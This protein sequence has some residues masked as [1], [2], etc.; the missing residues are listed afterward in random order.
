MRLAQRMTEEGHHIYQLNTGN[1]YPFGFEAP[2]EIIRDVLHNAPQSQGYIASK[3][4]FSARKAVMQECQLLG[5]QGVDTEDIYMGNGVSELISIALQALLNNGDEVLIPCPDYPL[6]TACTS[7]A[8]GRPRHY[9]CDESNDWQPDLDDIRSKINSRSKAL[10]IISPNNPTGTVYSEETLRELLEIARENRLLVFSD[11]IYQKITFHHITSTPLASLC[12]DVFI[13][14]FNGLSKAYRLPGFRVGWMILSGHGKHYATDFIEGLDILSSMRLCSNVPS[15][16]AV[17]TALGGYQSVADL[18]LPQ[19]RLNQQLEYCHRRIA[20]IPGLSCVKPKGAL[21]FFPKLDEKIY[22]VPDD[23]VFACDLLC[24]KKIFLVQ[25]TGF[26][27]KDS[28]HFRITFLPPVFD[29]E[30]IF[31]RLADFLAHYNDYAK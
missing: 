1:T 29:L 15:Q 11:E 9:L 7:L 26:N 18:L 17:Q 12:D 10:V 5:I 2:E 31:D 25:G 20:E 27:I 30:V 6:W 8:G 28:Q 24:D 4:L 19:N 23:E 22:P 13:I 16:Y 21:Y 14:T 3:G